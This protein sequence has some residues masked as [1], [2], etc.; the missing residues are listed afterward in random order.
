L[1]DLARR[2]GARGVVFLIQK[3]CTPHLTDIPIL[4][5][6]LKEAGL[7]SLVIEMEETGVMEGQTATRLQGFFEMM[8]D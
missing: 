2:S 5:R 3:F 4:G 1:I 6:E 7:P 8:G